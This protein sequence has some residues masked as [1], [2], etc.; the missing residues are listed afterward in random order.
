MH[1]KNSRLPKLLSLAKLATLRS[2][3][4]APTSIMFFSINFKY[5]KPGP[6]FT[7]T[8]LTPL[9]LN[10]VFEPAPI[11][12]VFNFFFFVSARKSNN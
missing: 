5:E 9:S 2:S 3:V 8:P 4:A 10:S 1:D 12:V 6:S 11:I 7:T